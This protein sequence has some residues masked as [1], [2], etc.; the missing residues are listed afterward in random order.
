MDLLPNK[1]QTNIEQDIKKLEI[2]IKTLYTLS[3]IKNSSIINIIQLQ[4]NNY[5][6][7]KVVQ[8]RK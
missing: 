8:F 2:Q 5:Q 4:N 1:Y 6:P 7:K 3:S